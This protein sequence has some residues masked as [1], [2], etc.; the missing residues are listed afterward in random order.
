V[1]RQDIQAVLTRLRS[2]DHPVRP[3]ADQSED[4][5]YTISRTPIRNYGLERDE[6][7]MIVPHGAPGV[8]SE[9]PS[10][11]IQASKRRKVTKGP[12]G[13]SDESENLPVTPSSQQ[14]SFSPSYTTDSEMTDFEEGSS[15]DSISV[16]SD[17][18]VPDLT[19]NDRPQDNG[20]M[21]RSWI[22]ECRLI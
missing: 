5:A 2:S 17:H 6:F 1:E 4:R 12:R 10:P 8:V 18:G 21:S 14:C 9:S 11:A 22:R 20:T 16:E 3:R 13:T 7:G 19:G 15:D